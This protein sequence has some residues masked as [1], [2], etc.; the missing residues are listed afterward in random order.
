MLTVL[1]FVGCTNNSKDAQPITQDDSSS[2]VMNKSKEQSIIRFE[3]TSTLGRGDH[4][5]VKKFV[6]VG[7]S[8]SQ[9]KRLKGRPVLV[10]I[11]WISKSQ[12]GVYRY[13]EPVTNVLNPTFIETDLEVLKDKIKSHYSK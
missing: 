11:G 1:F 4:I 3:E 7:P 12:D 8:H 10:T 2:I 6:K 13:Y 9:Y 5:E